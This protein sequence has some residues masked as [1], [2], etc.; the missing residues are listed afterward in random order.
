[1]TVFSGESVD[2]V[3]AS[4]VQQ[5]LVSD[6]FFVSKLNWPSERFRD[7]CAELGEVIYEAD[8]KLG[9]SRP[10]NYQLPQKIDFHTDH[11][12]AEVVA[13][14]CLVPDQQ[15]GA[16]QLLDLWPIAQRLGELRMED[17]ARVRVADNAAWGAGDA[18]PLC[19]KIEG[20]WHF[21]YVPWLSK[22]AEDEKAEIA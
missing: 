9:A 16:M 8:V 21:H 3:K 1:M 19:Q 15:G 12:S 18:V 17:L 20:K 13:W 6:G 14:H 10:R 4:D 7:I 2:D 5:A 11:I 22:F